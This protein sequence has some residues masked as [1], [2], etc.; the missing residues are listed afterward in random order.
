MG[1]SEDRFRALAADCLDLAHRTTDQG[2]RASLLLMAQRW[3][4]LASEKFGERRFDGLLD[5]FNQQQ[6]FDRPKT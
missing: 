3:L 5:D 4:E 2:A 6:M 1:H